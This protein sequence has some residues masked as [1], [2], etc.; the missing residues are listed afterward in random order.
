LWAR[1]LSSSYGEILSYSPLTCFFTFPF[2][3][4][5]PRTVIPTVET[6]GKTFYEARAA[7]MLST[8][9]GLTKTY[10]ALEDPANTDP[11]VLDLRRLTEAMDRAVLDAYG[12]TD[13]EVPP[14][15]PCTPAEREAHQA[16]EDE[17]IDRL[18]VLN[19]ERA[20]EEERLGLTKK[21]KKK[22]RKKTTEKKS[23]KKKTSNKTR[24][25]KQATLFDSDDA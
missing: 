25:K 2:P 21:S 13:I 10:N 23:T 20:R 5:D 16:F 12:W 18:Y 3:K 11:A 6:A 22:G 7:F 4:S 1:F 14:Y 19:A 24:T 15:C 8:N 17:V 9:Q